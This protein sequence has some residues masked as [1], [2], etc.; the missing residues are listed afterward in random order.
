MANPKKLAN[1][2]LCLHGITTDRALVNTFV[3][4]KDD[5]IAQINHLIAK[6]YTIVK[7]SQYEA[8]QNGTTTY[9]GPIACVIYD[10]GLGSNDVIVPWHISA[11]IPCGLAII[12]ARLRKHS[13]EDGFLSW[14]TLGGWV[15][16]GLVEVMSH[17]HNIHYTCLTAD[18]E[19]GV[20]DIAPIL[21]GPCWLDTGDY[22]W[23]RPGDSRWYWDQSFLDAALSMPLIGTDP[24]NGTTLLTTSLKVTPKYTGSVSLLRFYTTLSSPTSGTG[25]NATVQIRANG[26]LVFNGVVAQKD[27]GGGRVQWVER[28]FL[29]INLTTAFNVTAGTAVTLEFKTMTAGGA[30]M[31]VGCIPTAEDT[32][33]NCTTN[34]QGFR[35]AGSE[36]APDRW[37]QYTD[38]PANQPWPV[39]PMLILGS[40][41]GRAATRDEYTTYIEADIRAS[42]QALK[43]YTNAQWTTVNAWTGVW[44]LEGAGG[45]QQLGWSNPNKVSAMVK[46]ISPVDGVVE[47]LKLTLGPVIPV[48][49]PVEEWELVWDEVQLRNYNATF[50]IYI[51]SNGTGPWRKIGTFSV[52]Q[53]WRDMDIEITPTVWKAKVVKYMLFVPV[54]RGPTG[55]PEQHTVY[56]ISGVDLGI[57]LPGNYA[58]IPTQLCYPFGAYEPNWI[59]PVPYLKEA[60]DISITLRDIFKRNGITYAYTIQ[61]YRNFK[62][63]TFQGYELRQSEYAQGRIM[64][65]GTSP[66]NVTLNL[67]DAYTGDMFPNVPHKGL[68][69]QV[70]LEGDIVG[71]GTVRQ[72]AGVIDYFAFDAWAFNGQGA[73]GTPDI[74]RNVNPINDGTIWEGDLYDNE[75]L[76]LQDR[77]AYALIIINNNLGTGEPD[78]VIAA[79]IFAHPEAYIEK[80][81][82]H[83]KAG[84]WDGITSNIEGAEASQRALAT[85][86]YKKLGRRCHEEGLMLHITAPATTNTAYDLPSWTGWCDH[87]AIIPYVDGMKIMSYTETAEWSLPGPAAPQVFWDLVYNYLAAKIPPMFKHRILAGGRAFGTIWYSATPEESGYTTYHEVIAEAITRALPIK[88]GDTEMT[89]S[90][91]DPTI[92]VSGNQFVPITLQTGDIS[93]WCG[94]PLTLA[95]SQN[96]AETRGF[97]GIGI[98]KIDDGDIDEFYPS[99]RMF[100]KSHRLYKRTHVELPGDVPDFEHPEEPPEPEPIVLPAIGGALQ[101]GFYAGQ[102]L[103]G[104]ITYALILSPRATGEINGP[105]MQTDTVYTFTGN[106]S[107]NDGKLIQTN[108]VTYGIAKFPAQQAAKALAIGGY[109]DWYIPSKLEMEILYRNFKPGTANNVT[110]SGANASAVPPTSN[111]TTTNPTR[112][113]LTDFRATGGTNH[114]TADYYYT[115]TQGPGGTAFAHAKRFTNG[116]DSQDDISFDYPV[117]VIRRVAIV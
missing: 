67:L 12:T 16:T 68:K 47:F 86:F 107:V 84:K 5:V 91:S 35:L 46:A 21:E 15:A 110:T 17:T 24:Y 77:G 58:S 87:A 117:R 11:G 39:L 89:W 61:S 40:G 65:L 64:L 60:K 73:L 20:V 83:A 114:L 96:E 85:E 44:E 72:R 8:W 75:R 19:T 95:R 54:N 6:G 105:P 116:A 100:G 81:I 97:G 2:V 49:Y 57:H 99:N 94:T 74:V 101:G 43:N 109:T 52:W 70:S 69:Y 106:T 51:A 88:T 112:T 80:M 63:D 13:Q 103:I 56:T 104:T 28:E 14:G 3:S 26:T 48:D 41:T 50:D 111:Y 92:G 23:I 108:M 82:E 33:F 76:Y 30:M 38:Y 34:S 18:L 78:P 53:V 7:P 37:W 98:W 9:V 59:D 79:D 113:A 25:Y 55:L 115:A 1:I 22:V 29:T 93:A 4:H 90:T 71:H 10:D 45:F 31:S 27:Y 42:Q 36:G 32:L 102:I 62:R 66:L